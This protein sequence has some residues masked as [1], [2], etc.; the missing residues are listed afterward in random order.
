MTNSSH[1]M[2]VAIAG[3]GTLGKRWTELLHQSP[4]VQLASF[5]DP[6]IGDGDVFQWLENYPDIPQAKT[7]DA[8]D[9]KVEALIVTASSPL[10]AEIV[11][12]ALE[13]GLHVLV[14]KRLPPA[15]PMQRR[16]WN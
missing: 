6:L 9:N 11:Q 13:L 3:L 5:V 15:S 8:L 14:E 2:K 16:W 7:L 4:D 12:R 10:H 1:V